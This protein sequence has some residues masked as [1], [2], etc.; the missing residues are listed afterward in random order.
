[1]V[2]LCN[3]FS[4]ISLCIDFGTVSLSVVNYYCTTS[5]WLQYCITVHWFQYC[6]TQ[7]SE[8][9]LYHYTMTSVLYHCALISVLYHS[10]QII[11]TVPLHNDFSNY[12]CFDFS[13]VSLSAVNYYCTTTQWFQYYITVHWFQYCIT[14]CSEL[15]LYH[16]TVISVLSRHSLPSAD[17]RRAVVSFWRKN[18]HNTG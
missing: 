11:I 16:Y 7:C 3:D 6:I 18:V 13:T 4:T 9:L 2:P 5:Q 8:L 14:Q 17:S 15:L 12:L 10:V 1:M